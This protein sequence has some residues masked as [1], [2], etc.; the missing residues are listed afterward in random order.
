MKKHQWIQRRKS[1]PVI[2][3]MTIL[4]LAVLSQLVAANAVAAVTPPTPH[5]VKT[6]WMPTGVTW[7]L[8]VTFLSGSRQGQSANQRSR[9]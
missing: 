1:S 9:S 4:L 8:S 7:T 6:R 2:F 5:R 3:G